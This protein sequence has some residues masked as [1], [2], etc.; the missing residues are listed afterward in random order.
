MSLQLRTFNSVSN[1]L[2]DCCSHVFFSLIHA[3]QDCFMVARRRGFTLIEL[4]V[5]IAVIGVLVSLFLPAVQ[6]ARESARKAQCKNVS[7]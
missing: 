1:L 3:Q 4:L 2:G 6:Q 5:V 7:L